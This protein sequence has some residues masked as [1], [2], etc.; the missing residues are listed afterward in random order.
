MA[1]GNGR[2]IGDAIHELKT[3]F[4]EFTHTRVAMLKAEMRD[5]ATAWKLAIPL[6]IAAA[7]VAVTAWF[8]I[9]GGLV[10]LV[11]AWFQPSPYA[12][13]FGAMI[14]GGV[15]L[16]IGGILGWAAYAEFRKAGVAPTRTM[17][18][19]E[20]DKEWLANNRKAA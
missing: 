2:S 19:L 9:T 3:E 17:R 16:L 11:A 20:Q 15:Y 12:V 4:S 6:G 1:N 5:K 7:L 8:A 10:A 14:V 13:F 18:V